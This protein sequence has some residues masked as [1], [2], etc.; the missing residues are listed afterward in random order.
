M[1]LAV[2]T[3]LWGTDHKKLFT[4]RTRPKSALIDPLYSQITHRA[5]VE[6]TLHRQ[7]QS[8]T[9]PESPDYAYCVHTPRRRDKTILFIVIYL[10]IN[11]VTGEAFL[12]PLDAF[13]L[14]F[15]ILQSLF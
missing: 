8:A 2:N 14:L 6:C 11:Q 13:I 9:V 10:I 7:N 5:S 3:E 12:G 4:F 1:M 15:L